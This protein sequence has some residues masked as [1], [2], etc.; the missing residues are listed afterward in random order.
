[1]EGVAQGRGG[2]VGITLE[3]SHIHIFEICNSYAQ[4]DGQMDGAGGGGCEDSAG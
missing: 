4:T 3:F 1:M 2:V